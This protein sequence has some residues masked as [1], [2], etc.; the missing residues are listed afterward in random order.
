VITLPKIILASASPRRAEILRI[1]NWP[2]ETLPVNI[3]ETRHQGE[4]AATYVER[5]AREKAETAAARTSLFDVVGA[6]TTVAIDGHILEKPTDRDDAARMLRLLS[7]R[8]HEVL[9]GVAIVKRDTADIKVARQRTEVKFA[10]MS[11]QEIEMY[12]ATGEPMDKAG[13]YAIQGV[14]ARYIEEI[15]GE[16]FNVMG[17]PLRLLYEL[18]TKPES[19]P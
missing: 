8:W 4:P 12:V 9:T 3:D 16:Y 13:A 11:D 2:F 18:L 17:L 14:G 5:L 19:H 6:D 15:R 7:D 1:A 10:A